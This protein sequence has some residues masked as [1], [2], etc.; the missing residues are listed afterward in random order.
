[1]KKIQY[2]A[3]GVQ[4]AIVT[5]ISIQFKFNVLI[6]MEICSLVHIDPAQNINDIGIVCL[7]T[8]CYWLEHLILSGRTTITDW[9]FQFIGELPKLQHLNVSGCSSITDTSMLT[10]SQGFPM[11][12]HLNL[13]GC[14]QIM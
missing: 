2:N 5:E 11:L 4:Y 13:S 1:M 14:Q 6:P 8:G 12:Q 3:R 7:I 9:I 10:L